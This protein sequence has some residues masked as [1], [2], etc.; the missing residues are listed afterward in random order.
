MSAQGFGIFLCRGFVSH[1]RH[2]GARLDT[3]PSQLECNG[4]FCK[5]EC[6]RVQMITKARAREL[7]N[8]SRFEKASDKLPLSTRDGPWQGS[9]FQDSNDHGNGV[10]RNSDLG[11]RPIRT[12]SAS[13][14]P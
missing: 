8:Q 3:A 10:F 11:H 14:H 7:S 2:F 1:P 6:S 9:R 13:P 4:T 5:R 12:I